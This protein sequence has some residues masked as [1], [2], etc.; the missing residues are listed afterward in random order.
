MT[1]VILTPIQEEYDSLAQSLE[2]R[3]LTGTEQRIGKLSGASYGSEL[4][5]R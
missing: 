1:L 4:R 5:E 3:G 2:R